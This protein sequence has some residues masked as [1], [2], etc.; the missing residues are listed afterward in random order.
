MRLFFHAAAALCGRS[1]GIAPLRTAPANLRHRWSLP[2]I[3]QSG[4]LEEEILLA[5]PPAAPPLWREVTAAM[6][7]N[8]HATNASKGGQFGIQE[9]GSS[10][11][12]RLRRR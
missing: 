3:H 4:V 6:S 11:V 5:P 8:C 9:T 10:P 1:H 2:E 7:H 12:E